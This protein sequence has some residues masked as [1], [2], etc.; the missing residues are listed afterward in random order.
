LKIVWRELT[1]TYLQWETDQ[2]TDD[3]LN[4]TGQQVFPLD[5]NVIYKLIS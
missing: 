2:Y 1:I 4:M 5:W 3:N